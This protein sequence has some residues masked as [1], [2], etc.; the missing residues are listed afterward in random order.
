[1]TNIKSKRRQHGL[2]STLVDVHFR[3]VE[4]KSSTD[5]S[6]WIFAADSQAVAYG[7]GAKLA[8][9]GSAKF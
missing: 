1:M 8:G 3:F 9:L 2:P 5:F 6:L 4:A 7:K